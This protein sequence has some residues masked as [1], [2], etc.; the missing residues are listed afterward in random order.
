M[1]LNISGRTDI[2]AFYTPWFINR[3]KAGFVD[4]RN[5]INSKMISRIYFKDVDIFLFCT[6]NPLPII[7]YLKELDKPIIFQVTITPYKEDIEPNVIDKQ[8]IIESI[9]IISDIVGIDNIFIRYD[10]I[11]I[12]NK[13][14]MDYHKKAFNK[15]CKLLNGYVKHIIISFLDNYKNVEKNIYYIKPKTLSKSDYQVLGN[16][17]GSIAKQY[18]MDI[19]TCYEDIDLS[20]YGF[21]DDVCVSQDYAYKLTGKRFPRWQG[22]NCGCVEL[23]D[24][25]AYNTCNHLCKYCY[26]NYNEDKVKYN[27]L[28]HDVNSSLLIGNINSD[29]I[30]KIRK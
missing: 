25:G 9:K 19:R 14:T 24:I 4:V 16:S 28:K 1:I 3:L 22:R 18:D 20:E 6:K 23:V 29:D 26:A 2:V 12:N 13:Y 17:F 11:F 15:L 8:K 5:P 21:S 30:I 10:P 27:V 7:P